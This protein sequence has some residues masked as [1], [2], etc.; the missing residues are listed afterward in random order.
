MPPNPWHRS[1]LTALGLG[2]GLVIPS[3]RV[4]LTRWADGH[5]TVTGP[6]GR[7]TTGLTLDGVRAWCERVGV[8]GPTAEDVEWLTDEVGNG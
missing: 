8:S 5:Y 4:A 1:N 3:P 7:T 6:D 2:R